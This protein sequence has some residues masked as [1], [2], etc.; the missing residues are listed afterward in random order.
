MAGRPWD[1]VDPDSIR[2]PEKQWQSQV[3]QLADSCRWLWYHTRDS[4][5]SPEGFPD[6]V[7]ARPGETIFAELKVEGE[8][9]DPEQVIW[10]DVLK[11]NP[12]NEVYVW[13]PDD[14]FDIVERL[15][16][17]AIT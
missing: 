11:S 4:R 15:Q 13:W 10:N 9:L 5:K 17:A 1:S 12:N 7:L 6:L 8:E 3:E 2:T 14:W 16:R